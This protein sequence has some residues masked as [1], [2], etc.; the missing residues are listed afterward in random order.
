MLAAI[1]D[2]TLE[3]GERLNDDALCS[4]LG[5]SRTPVREAIT[6]LHGIGLV[7]IE[8]NRF[9]KVA[10]LDDDL[11][12]EASQ[13]LADLHLMGRQW[14]LDKLTAAERDDMGKRLRALYNPIS[15]HEVEAPKELLDLKGELVRA[16]GNGLLIRVEKD[17]DQGR[18]PRCHAPRPQALLRI[19]AHCCRLLG[20]DSAARHGALVPSHHAQH[21]HAPLADRRG[22]HA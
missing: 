18:R 20:G 10:S 13:F 3:P 22:P 8:A 12:S 21:L 7:E 6:Q 9:T 14:G 19:G 16:S 2:G 4:W 5:V 17:H 15:V 11:Y 1:V